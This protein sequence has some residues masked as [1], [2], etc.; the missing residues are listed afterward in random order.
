MRVERV[1]AEEPGPLAGPGYELN[2]LLGAPSGLV[3][4]RRH[5]IRTGRRD[6]QAGPSVL[7]RN[8]PQT[9]R[10]VGVDHVSGIVSL[11][12]HPFEVRIA[13]RPVPIGHVAV[14]KIVEAVFAAVLRAIVSARQ[15]Q[16]ADEAA[17]VTG[18]GQDTADELV[19]KTLRVGLAP[20]PNYVIGAWVRAGQETRPARR[21]DRVLAIGMSEGHALS[22]QP[23]EIG[24]ADLGITQSGYRV[25]T[26]LIGA[27]QQDVR[28]L[29]SAA[30]T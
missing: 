9:G 5:V 16:L 29:F 30:L 3:Q 15:V 14:L 12:P 7:G 4:L 27:I 21:A 23:V 26:L 13:L 2:R 22:R 28:A 20:V 17:V 19:D 24:R 8:H 11:K 18:L 10:V 25:E 6:L 1:N